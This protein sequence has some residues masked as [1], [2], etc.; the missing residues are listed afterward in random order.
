MGGGGGGG[1]IG[2][3][4]TGFTGAGSTGGVGSAAGSAGGGCCAAASCALPSTAH[5]TSMRFASFRYIRPPRYRRA[6]RRARPAGTLPASQ[7]DL[8]ADLH[9]LVRR[10]PEEVG[11][12]AGISMHHREHDRH[13]PAP[14]AARGEHRLTP[15]E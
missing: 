14:P 10:Q 3:G 11:G 12:R 15:E 13:P 9:H 7:L 6:A 2:A 4:S 8:R 1:G 5:V